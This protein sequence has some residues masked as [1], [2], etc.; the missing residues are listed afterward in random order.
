ML[1]MRG[2]LVFL[3]SVDILAQ[4]Y[5]ATAPRSENEQFMTV[6]QTIQRQ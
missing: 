5:I 3:K 1:S 4:A 2:V 6:C